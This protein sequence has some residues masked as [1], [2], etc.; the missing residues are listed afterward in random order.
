MPVDAVQSKSV[1]GE[2]VSGHRLIALVGPFQSGKTTLLEALLARSG[3]L[4][5]QGNVRDGSTIGDSTA[6]ARAHAM[7]VECN[8][9]TTD[10]LG[11]RYTFVDCPGSVEFFSDMRNVL[12]VCDAAVVVCEPDPRK[13][14]ALQL[15][16]HELEELKIP[17]LIFLNKIDQAS[18]GVR[19][20]L[21]LLQPASRAPLLLRQIP[22]WEDGIATGFIDLALERAFLYREHAPSTIIEMPA[23]DIAREK[24]ARFSMLER[25]ADYDDGLMEELLSDIDPPRDQ[26]FDDLARDLREGLVAPVLIG[27]AERGNGI[28][29]LLKALRHETPGVERTRERLGVSATGGPL[30]YV[31]R[32]VHTA[33]GGKLS[34]TRAL[35]GAFAD[36]GNI[37]NGNEN[38]RISGISRLMGATAS[39]QE[40][41]AEGDTAALGRLDGM[42]T[43]DLVGT[44]QAGSRDA[45]P[46]LGRFAPEPVHA[47]TVTAKDRKDETKL[48]AAL[49]KLCDEDTAL[50]FT[51]DQETGE[52]HLSGQG[53][54]H[55][56]VTLERLAARFGIVVE[57]R[58]PQ[59]AY[60]ETIRNPVTVRGRHKKQ[61][62]GHGQ[63]GDVVLDV[64]P[65]DRG[66]G[67]AFAETVHGGAV[68]KQY[69]SS[70][71]AGCG[72][73]LQKGPFG[74]PVVDVAVTLTDGSYHTVDSSDMAFRTA[75]RMGLSEALGK[76]SPVLLEP[77]LAVEIMVPSEAMARATAMVSSRRGQILG[78]DSRPGWSQWDVVQA[79]IPEAEMDGFIV[80]LRSATSGVGSFT[81]R[82]DHLAE[83]AGKRAEAAANH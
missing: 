29:R 77:V 46:A 12:P 49:A 67:F 32:T 35:R 55:L 74:Y 70:V 40:R 17:R 75:A 23:D 22:V 60:R 4:S 10:F 72:D 47:F 80:E 37:T 82:F 53:E 62:G 18:T 66:A 36:N 65:L 5:R 39:K 26:V 7:S 25:L 24:E 30:A 83:T 15:I 63:F 31:M 45:P 59:V 11:D 68:P 3:A 42:A 52:L 43:G 21:G 38:G 73:A 78:Y 20:T 50:G 64:K 71:E 44:D 28:T 41:L 27:A 33:H 48:A 51:H 9:A 2:H 13:I 34:V 6:E 58:A 79:L 61:S 76:A 54:M 81:T 19:D 1:A 14:P 8:F 57:A 56:R 69:F 16:L